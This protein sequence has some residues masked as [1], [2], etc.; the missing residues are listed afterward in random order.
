MRELRRLP[1][2][3]AAAADPRFQGD[4]LQAAIET[5]HAEYHLVN[6]NELRKRKEFKKMEVIDPEAKNW[7]LNELKEIGRFNFERIWS[8][9]LKKACQQTKQR[10]LPY[11]LDYG[12][13]VLMPKL[14]KKDSEAIF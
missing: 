3:R 1:C 14:S 9:M 10:Q 8:T 5:M 11:L 13:C 12:R 6:L 4:R 7:L 2:R